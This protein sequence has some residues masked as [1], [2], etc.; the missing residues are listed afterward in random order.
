MQ[1]STDAKGHF[2][3]FEDYASYPSQHAR[4][5][6]ASVH[7]P[8]NAHY[9]RQN[10][11]R[12]HET[13]QH[14]HEAPHMHSQ[15]DSSQRD[16]CKYGQRNVKTTKT[17]APIEGQHTYLPSMPQ[18]ERASERYNTPQSNSIYAA[19]LVCVI[20]TLLPVFVAVVNV[21]RTPGFSSNMLRVPYQCNIFYLG[22]F[23]GL[24]GITVHIFILSL[25]FHK[26]FRCG[27]YL[28]VAAIGLLVISVEHACSNTASISVDQT[29]YVLTIGI[30]FGLASQWIFVSAILQN[31]SRRQMVQGGL[32]FAFVL[33][34]LSVLSIMLSALNSEI[35][36]TKSTVYIRIIPLS[37]ALGIYT[38][39]TYF[40]LLRVTILCN[41]M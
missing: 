12:A 22:L 14:V 10:T 32:G 28:S 20:C 11:E 25:R 5:D 13:H 27:V 6:T 39:S 24:P 7:V 15:V 23:V 19:W 26:G 9:I 18:Q 36:H 41:N 33:A 29:F 34:T 30:F 4:Q 40:T 1:A 16:N 31:D 35:P 37:C 38:A 3:R 17:N 21:M 8:S 2:G